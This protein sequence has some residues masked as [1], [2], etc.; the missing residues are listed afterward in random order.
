MYLNYSSSSVKSSQF[1]YSIGR[2]KTRGN[3]QQIAG[4]NNW[5][6]NDKIAAGRVQSSSFSFNFLLPGELMREN[7]EIK[8]RTRPLHAGQ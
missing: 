5:N 6:S 4:H 7:L 3:G 2:N 8:A 1:Y